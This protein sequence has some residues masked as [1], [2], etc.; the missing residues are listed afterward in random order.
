MRSLPDLV[1][2][3]K[4]KTTKYDTSGRR[5]RLGR[6]RVEGPSTDAAQ[7]AGK[8]KGAAQAL[9][10]ARQLLAQARTS[11]MS[12]ICICILEE[13]V[14]KE[15]AAMRQAQPLGQRIDQARARFRRAVEAREK[16]MQA[17]LRTQ[18]TFEQEQQKLLQA[19]TALEK[20]MQDAKLPVMSVPQ[21]N[22][23]LV[24]SLEALTGI[25]D[26]MWNTV[27]D[28]HRKTWYM[29]SKSRG[30]FSKP[31]LSFLSQESGEDMGVDFG[32][33]RGSEQWDLGC[34]RC[35]GDA[36]LQGGTCS[37]RIAWRSGR[38]E[39]RQR[40]AEITATEENAHCGTAGDGPE[41][42]PANADP[43]VVSTCKMNTQD[44]DFFD[45]AQRAR[46]IIPGL[47]GA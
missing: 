41:S 23:N 35:R 6:S 18:V 17:M 14:Q 39:S 2:F 42:S 12:K 4:Q 44:T 9:A 31:L 5:Q 43:K 45:L 7:P 36:G 30:I 21:V 1:V 24:R 13:E 11:G 16:A 46:A 47:A 40:H 10:Q 8:P 25:V 22:M 3:A 15:E 20:L 29:R 37:R 33:Q 32:A 38:S 26:K 27:Q 34:G 19:H 28:H